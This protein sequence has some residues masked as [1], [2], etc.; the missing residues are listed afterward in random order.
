[1]TTSPAHTTSTVPVVR[2]GWDHIHAAAPLLATTMHDYLEQISVSLRPTSIEAANSDLARAAMF[3]TAHD[4]TLRRAR[5]IHRGHVEAFKLALATNPTRLGTLPKP[6][7]RRRCLSALRMFFLRIIEWDWPDAPARNPMFIGDL[8][9]QDE[10]L[11]R[12]LDDAAFTRVMHTISIDTNPIRRLV[13]EL[14]ARTGMRVSE[15]CGLDHDA[16]V[17]LGDTHW[18]RV[19]I[20]KLRN[21]RYVPLHPHLVELIT[22]W[23]HTNP[24]G[25]TG[26]LLTRGDQPINR[27]TITRMCHL[28]GRRAGVTNLHPTASATPSPPKPSTAA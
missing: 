27:H 11:P 15:I 18:L 4:P 22:T 26:R 16:M 7:T 17:H 9:R 5:D 21:D 14:L 1:M 8:P 10:P 3:F 19:P 20:G 2:A 12:F 13:M 6:A 24:A 28:I 25:P 23:R